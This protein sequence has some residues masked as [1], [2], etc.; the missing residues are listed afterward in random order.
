MLDAAG[1]STGKNCR[2]CWN[3]A[4]IVPGG[5]LPEVRKL[6][7]LSD[8]VAVV[9]GAMDQTAGAIGA[10]NRRRRARYGNDRH[11]ALRRCHAGSNPTSNHPS[12][13]TLYRHYR[14]RNRYLM[15]TIS[16]DGGHVSQVV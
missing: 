2:S 3:A 14:A 1:I 11:R 10:G 5:V 15:I 16:D 12:R 6:L 7:G 9:T 4:Q 13:V 8:D